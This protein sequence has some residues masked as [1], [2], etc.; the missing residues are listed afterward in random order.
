MRRCGGSAGLGDFSVKGRTQPVSRP[1]GDEAGVGTWETIDPVGH[2]GAVGP[3]EAER[4]EG[5]ASTDAATREL[6][7]DG[8]EPV[9][10]DHRPGGIRLLVARDRFE[11]SH[12]GQSK[13]KARAPMA[14][15]G[16]S[17]TAITSGVSRTS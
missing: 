15:S 16:M 12:P 2:L 9:R 7:E 13:V 11:D 8:Y 6:A 4:I 3:G 14:N 10:V 17:L 5:I 1:C